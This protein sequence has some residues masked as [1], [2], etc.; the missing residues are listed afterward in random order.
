MLGCCM[1][2]VLSHA[3]R[4]PLAETWL[5]SLQ[6]I[7]KHMADSTSS[8]VAAAGTGVR[9]FQHASSSAGMQAADSFRLL[10]GPS[11]CETAGS[12]AE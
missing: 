4:P 6:P 5:Q 10:E 8:T 7:G 2:S 11:G 3:Y 9:H 1:F 12:S